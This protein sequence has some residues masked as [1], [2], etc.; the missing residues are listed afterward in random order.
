M[1][2]PDME[3]LERMLRDSE[4]RMQQLSEVEAKLAEVTSRHTSEDG[5]VSV[6]LGGDGTLRHLEINPRAMRMDS[7]TLA[8]RIT[9]AFNAA[10]QGLQEAVGRAMAD[11]LGTENIGD[12]LTE[13]T[14]VRNS[15]DGVL[16]DVS[17]AV[18]D[19]IIQTNRFGRR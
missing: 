11:T 3:Q 2:T 15:M 13:A 1:N 14:E 17:R 19:A 8:E 4:R 10:Q 9:E 18:N 16:S 5:A 7:F 6:E 12:V